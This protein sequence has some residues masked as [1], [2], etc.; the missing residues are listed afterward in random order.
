MARADDEDR[1]GMAIDWA[2]DHFVRLFTRDTEDDLMLSW[3]ARA[4]WHELLRKFDKQGRLA[5]RRGARGIA[6]LIRVPV[7]VVE[8]ALPELLEDGRLV[9]VGE[10]YEAPNYQDANYT[11]R[12]TA[13]RK[14]YSR[15]RTQLGSCESHEV[16]RSH[17]TSHGVYQDQ[18]RSGSEH[19]Q[20][21]RSRVRRS[22]ISSDWLPPEPLRERAKELELDWEAE[23]RE[24]V[25]YWI[26]EGKAKADW[27]ETFR[28]RLEKR[29]EQL[30]HMRKRGRVEEERNVGEM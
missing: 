17:D 27:E 9:A 5:N 21:A 11:P 29:A 16:T 26:G 7:E 15:R 8:R 4:V 10:G 20:G 18:G 6:A 12:S 24:F 23:T 25:A 13:A 3:E 14:E 2:S 1:V 19:A 28:A 30:K 22:L